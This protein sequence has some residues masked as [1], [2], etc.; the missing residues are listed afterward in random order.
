M[1]PDFDMTDL[2]KAQPKTLALAM[3]LLVE[4]GRALVLMRGATTDDRNR[5]EE[6]FWKNFDGATQ[7]GVVALVRLWSLVDVFKARRLQ[8]LLLERGYVLLADAARVAAEQR[9]NMDWGF[10]PQRML[11]ALLARRPHLRV[12][13]GAYTAQPKPCD[14]AIAA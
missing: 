8:E 6:R 2:P 12:I 4:D 10:N 3:R 1:T 9:I 13:A 5:L 7:D 11:T 14:L